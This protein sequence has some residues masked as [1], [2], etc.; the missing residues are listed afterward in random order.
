MHMVRSNPKHIYRLDR[1][2][3]E[4]GYKEYLEVLVDE[5]AKIRLEKTGWGK[6]TG[7]GK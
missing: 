1:E 2:W 5:R 6:K 7:G 3:L 4:S